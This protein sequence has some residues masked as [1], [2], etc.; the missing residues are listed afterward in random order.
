MADNR[1]SLF[2]LVD[3]ETTSNAFSIKI[4][5]NDTV[6]DFKDLIKAKQSLDFDDIHVTIPVVPANKNKPIVLNEIIFP[7]ELNPTDDLSDV[8][9]ESPPKRTIHIIVQSPPQ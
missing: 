2:C 1:M 3:G 7:M 4:P 6:D 5:S 8:F 9:K